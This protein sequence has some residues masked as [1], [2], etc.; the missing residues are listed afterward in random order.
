MLC[1]L[2]GQGQRAGQAIGLQ[3]DRLALPGIDNGQHCRCGKYPYDRRHDDQFDERHAGLRWPS[4]RFVYGQHAEFSGQRS[5]VLRR[6][7]MPQAE[8][9]RS[10]IAMTWMHWAG[11][12]SVPTPEQG[13]L[14]ILYPSTYSL[15]LGIDIPSSYLP[16]RAWRTSNCARAATNAAPPAARRVRSQYVV[17]ADCAANASTPPTTSTTINSMSVNPRR[18]RISAYSFQSS[19]ASSI[20]RVDVCSDGFRVDE[21]ARFQ[22]ATALYSRFA[23][24]YR[25]R[26]RPTR[27]FAR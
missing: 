26:W 5:P 18:G 24:V 13:W 4:F 20:A 27:P 25:Q 10:G 23:W 12:N 8:S 21:C 9:S 16:V 14:R 2:L 15:G 1:R 11:G 3:D 22:H 6:T 19:L 17:H 7:N